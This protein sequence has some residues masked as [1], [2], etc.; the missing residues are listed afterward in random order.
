MGVTT[1]SKKRASEK[2][3][4]E[5]RIFATTDAADGYARPSIFL[6][7]REIVDGPPAYS[8]IY[9]MGKTCDD[10]LR[11]LLPNI[12][13]ETG[14]KQSFT[15]IASGKKRGAAIFLS[16]THPSASGAHYDENHTLLVGLCGTRRVFL[17]SRRDWPLKMRS[18][19]CALKHEYDPVHDPS[20][21]DWYYHD[22][23]VG[24]AVLIPR[25]MWHSVVGTLQSVSLSIDV[26]DPFAL[27]LKPRTY[28]LTHD[29]PWT[30]ASKVWD[31]F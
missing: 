30:S 31:D 7:G 9:L 27:T 15:T 2:G 13:D 8:S 6:G 11:R 26:H 21:A 18:V 12:W 14:L 4:T 24:D 5:K 1:R 16:M 20:C 22:L 3:D 19:E 29:I 23:H 28:K 10:L 17:S 25:G